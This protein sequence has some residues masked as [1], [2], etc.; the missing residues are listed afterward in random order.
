MA[1]MIPQMAVQV[2]LQI[3]SESENI[4]DNPVSFVLRAATAD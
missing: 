3:A 4:G 2:D 1:M